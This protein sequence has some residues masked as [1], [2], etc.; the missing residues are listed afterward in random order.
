MKV[1]NCKVLIIDDNDSLLEALEMFLSPHF[2]TIKLLKSPET[3]LSLHQKYNF[4]IIL[5]DM[6]FKAGI[7]SGNEG[8]YWMNEILKKDP[9]A[10]I[11]MITAYGDV[12]LAVKAIKE[13]AADFIQKSW[14]E[15]KILS[16]LIAAYRQRQSKL[17]IRNLKQKQ[18]HLSENQD[19]P[20]RAIIGDSPPMIRMFETINKVSGTDA[21]ILLLGENGTGKEVIAREIHRK[22][23]RSQEIFVK[24]DLGS[25]SETLFESE[26][27]GSKK[28]SF[29]GATS[30]RTGRFEIASG[31]TL[32]LDE[33]ANIPLSLQSKLLSAI[34][35][36]EVTP[37]GACHPVQINV[38]LICATNADINLMVD[39]GTF[40]EDLLYRINTIQ[41][42]VPPLRERVKDIALLAGHFVSLFSEKYSKEIEGCDKGAIKAL[43]AH[44]WKGNVRELEHMIEK[45]VILCDKPILTRDDFA[46]RK[47][48]SHYNLSIDNFN[49]SD[50]EKE[51]IARAINSSDGNYSKAASKLGINRSTLYEKIKKYEL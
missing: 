44:N 17:E 7:N 27:F 30:D 21:N 41:I 2:G 26:L 20:G 39:Q 46:F 28:G 12:E 47:G 51:I 14:D 1:S 29:T 5:L 6:N 37:I 50:H 31:G 19:C 8:I 49:L 38:R 9:L 40:R 42:T 15:S 32:F 11:I 35:N 24:V 43:E 25:L 23:N 3:V 45:A 13:G 4:D 34:Q 33:I 16:T 22:S 18:T 48:Q 36:L 10:C